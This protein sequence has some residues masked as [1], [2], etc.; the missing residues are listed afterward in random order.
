MS[1]FAYPGEHIA[2]SRC[3]LPGSP[4]RRARKEGTVHYCDGCERFFVAWPRSGIGLMDGQWWDWREINLATGK[5]STENE[6]A[7]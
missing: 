5:P 2:N 1:D 4:S 3:S 6:A 7:R